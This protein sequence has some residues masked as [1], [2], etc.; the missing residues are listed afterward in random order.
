MMEVAVPE[1]QAV[2]D[3]EEALQAVGVREQ[4]EISLRELEQDAL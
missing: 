4:V 3:L 1:G 2:D